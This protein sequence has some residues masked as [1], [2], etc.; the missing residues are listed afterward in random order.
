VYGPI[1]PFAAATGLRPQE[2]IALHRADVRR[3]ERILK[4]NGTKTRGSVRDVPLTQRALQ[5]LDRMPAR[6]TRILFADASGDR[7]DLYNFRRSEWRPAVEA[8]VISEPARIYDLR[9]MFASNALAA[10]ITVFELAKIMGTSVRMIEK[11]Y[12]A[13]IG[14]D[15]GIAGRLDALDEAQL[16]QNA[17]AEG[18]R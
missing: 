14:G 11:H 10:N 9:S 17:E 5:A 8:A 6:M 15:A 1:V 7:I 3:D 12:G 16:E 2:W 13:L 4:V 18:S